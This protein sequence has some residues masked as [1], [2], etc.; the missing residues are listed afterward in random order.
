M[1]FANNTTGELWKS[2]MMRRK[3]IT[4]TIGTDLYSM[5]IYPRAFFEMFDATAEFDKWATMEV[6]DFDAVPEGMESFTL[7]GGL[8]AVFDYTGLASAAGPTFQYIIRTWLPDSEYILDG[9][10][11]FEILGEKYKKDDPSS[12][13]EIWI[14][15]RPKK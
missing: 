4:N 7:P 12:E 10:P 15:V 8:Y 14:P 3:E 13:E 6:S 9:R 5:Q 1:N 11:H 2:F